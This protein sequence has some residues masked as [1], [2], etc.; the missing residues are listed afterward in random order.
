M[1]VLTY[2]PQKVNLVVNEVVIT[3]FADG[4]MIEVERNEDA[5]YPYVGTKGE[6]SIAESADR[7]GT[8]K[9]TLKQ[10]SP[11][12]AYLNTLAKQ[13]GDDASFPVSI[14]N[15]N[16]N[17]QSASGTDCRVKKMAT[18]TYDKEVTEREF[19]IFV[20]DLDII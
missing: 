1:A 5:I 15:M 12:V 20:S 8:I 10:T 13:K 18:E 19:E 7:T 11:S 17:G 3:G 6:V 9:V 4:S 2:D 14:V 16:T